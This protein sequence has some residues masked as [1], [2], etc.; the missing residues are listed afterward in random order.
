MSC[1]ENQPNYDKTYTCNGGGAPNAAQNCSSYKTKA[2]CTFL[3]SIDGD[4]CKWVAPGGTCPLLNKSCD[5][6]TA[7]VKGGKMSCSDVKKQ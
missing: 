2:T 1:V 7:N 4:C 3:N 6:L 5:S